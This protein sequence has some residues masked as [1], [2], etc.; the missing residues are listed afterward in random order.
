M[1]FLC[2]FFQVERRRRD[3]INTWIMK[4]GKLI[5]DLFN[6]EAGPPKQNLMSKSGI[7]ARAC[8]YLTELRTEND[9]LRR[10]RNRDL[11]ALEQENQR[12][13]D[14]VGLLKQENEILRRQLESN[15]VFLK[16]PDD[17]ESRL[18]MP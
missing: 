14:E 15:G 18:I 1:T 13:Q 3:T 17:H 10:E 4:L 8:D 11:D 7:L 12:L 5:P 9:D 16:D 6:P 2:F